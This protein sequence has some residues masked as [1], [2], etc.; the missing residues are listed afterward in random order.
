MKNKIILLTICVL[1]SALLFTGCSVR[2]PA[3]AQ[4]GGP[5]SASVVYSKDFRITFSAKQYAYRQ[6]GLD[7]EKPFDFEIQIEYTGPEP[8]VKVW[9]GGSVGVVTMKDHLGEPLIYGTIT[10]IL[11]SSVWTPDEPHSIP[12]TGKGEYEYF[13]SL[14][15]GNYTAEAYVNF[16]LDEEQ[17]QSVECTL[18]LPFVIE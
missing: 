2:T 16:Y 4:S 8:E 18:E 9:H 11:K 6:S 3:G 7:K 10:S 13:G 1:S 17:T 15:K 14:D 12:W 5:V